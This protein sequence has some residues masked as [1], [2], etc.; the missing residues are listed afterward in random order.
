[1]FEKDLPFA[2][3]DKIKTNNIAH[4]ISQVFFYVCTSI[5]GAPRPYKSTKN[6]K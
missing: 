4:P 2:R 3:D 1:M 6:N 5:M